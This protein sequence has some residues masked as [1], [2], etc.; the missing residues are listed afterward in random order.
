MKTAVVTLSLKKYSPYLMSMRFESHS[1][2]N[3]D[4]FFSFFPYLTS[5]SIWRSAGMGPVWPSILTYNVT[6]LAK[7][8]ACYEYSPSVP[9]SVFSWE[10]IK[11]LNEIEYV[12]SRSIT[13]F[14]FLYF[15]YFHILYSLYLSLYFIGVNPTLKWDILCN[16]SLSFFL[17]YIS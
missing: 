8:M 11:D 9:L 13:I 7:E 14:L 10:S 12:I 6:N 1:D 16:L 17:I 3:F 15:I 2:Q 5:Y 4:L